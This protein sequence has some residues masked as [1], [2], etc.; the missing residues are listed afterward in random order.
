MSSYVCMPPLLFTLHVKISLLLPDLVVLNHTSCFCLLACDSAETDGLPRK[1][2]T[3]GGIWQVC[4][5][6]VGKQSVYAQHHQCL[7]SKQLPS[8]CV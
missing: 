4:A 6:V 5:Q 3:G 1:Y 8:A 7:Q 2:A